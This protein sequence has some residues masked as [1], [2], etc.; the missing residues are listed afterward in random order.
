VNT[1]RIH[2]GG[3]EFDTAKQIGHN[4]WLEA[5]HDFKTQVENIRYIIK[6]CGQDSNAFLI[7]LT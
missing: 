2:P 3:F 7:E 1:T 5:C 6:A 4:M